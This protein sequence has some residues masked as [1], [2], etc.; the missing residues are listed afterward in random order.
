[1]VLRLICKKSQM[2][3]KFNFKIS[4]MSKNFDKNSSTQ[5]PQ[6]MQKLTLVRAF[7]FINKFSYRF[8]QRERV[9]I[10]EC[11]YILNYFKLI[12]DHSAFTHTGEESDIVCYTKHF[13]NSYQNKK[14]S[15]NSPKQN[16]DKSVQLF[17]TNSMQFS[18]N[19][20]KAV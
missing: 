3:S 2:I 17:S 18:H 9:G 14:I 6:K 11:L 7:Y 5:T 16:S 8:C 19:S 15:S 13:Q 20:S 12:W 10:K 4:H 1:M